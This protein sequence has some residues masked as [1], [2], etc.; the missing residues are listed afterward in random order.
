MRIEVEIRYQGRVERTPALVNSGYEAP[1]P[2]IHIPLALARRLGFQVD[3]L[4]SV[5]YRVVGGE[6]TTLILGD[7]EVRVVT[8]DKVTDWVRAKAVLVVGEYEVL[9]SD[10]LIEALG[11]EI[12][13]PKSGLWR[14]HGE[15][16]VRESVRPR[17]WIT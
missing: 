13:K 10:A 14:F 3:R 15:A 2:E 8:S 7:V 6:V 4:H 5:T 12:I 9:L 17:Y 16:I 1:E 11:I